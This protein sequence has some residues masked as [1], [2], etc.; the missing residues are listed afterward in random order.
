MPILHYSY[1]T[2]LYSYSK[3]PISCITPTT[4][5]VRW[6]RTGNFS[7]TGFNDSYIIPIQDFTKSDII[8]I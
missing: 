1:D 7:Y 4:L 5:A 3:K 6:K 2:F 8:P